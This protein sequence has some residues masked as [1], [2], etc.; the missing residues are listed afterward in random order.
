MR[1]TNRCTTLL[2]NRCY[3]Y[4]VSSLSLNANRQNFP[5]YNNKRYNSTSQD[6]KSDKSDVD[7]A[8]SVGVT[9][10]L[11]KTKREKKTESQQRRQ[12]WSDA[13][14]KRVANLN[15]NQSSEDSKRVRFRQIPLDPKVVK[16]IDELKVGRRRDAPNHLGRPFKRI[17]KVFIR[18]QLQKSGRRRGMPDKLPQELKQPLSPLELL[19]NRIRFIGSASRKESFIKEQLPEVAFVGRSN[20][21]K[22]S[23]INTLTRSKT[24]RTSEKPGLTK[25]IS[26]YYLA[27]YICFVDL[28]GYGFALTDQ[29]TVS[30]WQKLTKEYISDRKILK[31][32]ILLIDARHGIKSSDLAMIDFLEE[33]KKTLSNSIYQNRHRR[34]KR[35]SKK[36]VDP[37]RRHQKM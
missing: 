23:L 35:H 2:K 5:D 21:G 36:V 19:F 15:S 18:K 16:V 7:N 9:A 10:P 28:P 31:R 30:D 8:A 20:V 27:N 3:Y 33:A 26:W 22:S 17:S 37:Q 4:R 12:S 24:V 29:S 32:V 34:S 11:N 13:A 25:Q 6:D 1:K 14:R